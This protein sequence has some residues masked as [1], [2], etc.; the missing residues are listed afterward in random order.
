[1]MK[2]MITSIK[3]Y[4]FPSMIPNNLSTIAGHAIPIKCC[5]NYVAVTEFAIGILTAG[6]YVIFYVAALFVVAMKLTVHR[7][8]GALL[9]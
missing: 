1:M 3:M 2:L 7:F 4:A 9:I 6:L 5:Y 8:N